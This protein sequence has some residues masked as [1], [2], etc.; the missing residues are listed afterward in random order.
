MTFVMTRLRAATLLCV[1]ALVLSGCSDSSTDSKYVGP[2]PNSDLL[3][4]GASLAAN[5]TAPNQVIVDTRS[6]TAYAAAHIPGAINIPITP[7]NGT[8]DVGGAGPDRTDLKP[9]SELAAALGAAGIR[10]TDHVIVCGTD[11]DWLAGRL[12]WMLEYLGSPKVSMLDGGFSKWAADERV[13]TTEATV[14]PAATFTPR[15]VAARLVDKD[16][17]LAH[18]DDTDHYAIVDS[19][20]VPDYNAARIPHAVNILVEDVLNPDLTMKTSLELEA[21]FASKG[22][23]REKTVYTHCYVGYRSSQGYFYFRLMGYDVSHYDGSWTDW[24]ADPSTPKE[25]S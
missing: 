10:D 22:V 5:L 12:F 20:N 11:I 2:Y 18:Y 21:L 1:A 8:F 17:V 25:H 4:S 19:R 23:S 9:A 6:A 13:T 16:D 7:G 3:V 15:V 14:L 24:N